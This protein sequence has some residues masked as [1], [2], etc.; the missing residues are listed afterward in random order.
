LRPNNPRALGFKNGIEAG[1]EFAIV[2]TNHDRIKTPTR[3][4]AKRADV[5]RLSRVAMLAYEDASARRLCPEP[6]GSARS[7]RFVFSTFRRQRRA[8]QIA[9]A[10]NR[11][12]RR[13]ARATLALWN[14]AR[15]FTLNLFASF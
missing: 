8:A 7:P 3:N 13:P 10:R 14:S 11:S 15:R 12:R 6:V 2:V 1:G 4:N 9:F 5:N